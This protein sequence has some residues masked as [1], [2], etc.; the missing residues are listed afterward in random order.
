VILGIKR[1]TLRELRFNNGLP[2][3]RT[4]MNYLLAILSGSLWYMQFFFYGLAHVRMGVFQF[5]SWVIHMSMLIFFSYIV[6]IILKEWRQV[7]K[8][9]YAV[10]IL[11]LVILISSFII[12]TWGSVR[13]EE[14]QEAHAYVELM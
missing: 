5:A 3:S 9:T 6:G 14:S 1:G 10:L 12:M 8:K 7:S 11:A 2:R 4:L 13:G